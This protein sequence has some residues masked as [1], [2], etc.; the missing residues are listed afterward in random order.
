LERARD[1]RLENPLRRMIELKRCFAGL[2]EPGESADGD[3]LAPPYADHR[4]LADR[5]A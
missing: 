1:A 3:P 5:F 2:R 4:T